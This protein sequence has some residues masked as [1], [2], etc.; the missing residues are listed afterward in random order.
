MEQDLEL[1][2]VITE[3]DSLIQRIGTGIGRAGKALYQTVVQSP[4][5]DV[6]LAGTI[7]S[8]FILDIDMVTMMLGALTVKQYFWG[9]KT[10]N[11]IQKSIVSRNRTISPEALR[12][13]FSL[14]KVGWCDHIGSRYAIKEYERSLH[15]L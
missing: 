9:W 1:S 5:A 6:L 14:N 15:E 11:H 12:R 13:T 8:H 3:E 4:D 2:D 10:Y 7:A